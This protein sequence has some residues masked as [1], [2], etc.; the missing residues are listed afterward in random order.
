MI[1]D[2][3]KTPFA[4]NKG[5]PPVN[6][7]QA[8]NTSK[9]RIYKDIR[10]SIILGEYK[11]G[12]KLNLEDLAAAFQTSV[13]P[14]REALQMLTQEDY[15]TAKPHAGFFVTRV[16]LKELQDLLELRRILE[17]ASIE[18]AAV[19]ISDHE[20]EQLTR[21]HST[22]PDDE[23]DSYTTNIVENHRFHTGIARSSG[24]Q[25]LAE[26]LGQILD[27]LARFFVFTHS[28]DEIRRRHMKVIE[29]LRT[30]DPDLARQ[31]IIDEVDETREITLRHVIEE[32]GT[33]WYLGSHPDEE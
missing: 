13:T 2:T 20:L 11:P 23:G 24:N 1:A 5:V 26:L 30:H 6:Q 14:V 3:Q 7:T 22:D 15:V 25:Q 27:R 12:Q 16:T 9:D 10:R 4:N 32:D 31:V 17:I 19:R 29:A 28:G 33:A 21:V 8:G 18:K